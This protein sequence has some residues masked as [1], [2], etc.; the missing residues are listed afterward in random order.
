MHIDTVRFILGSL[1]VGLGVSMLPSMGWSIYYGESGAKVA[2]FYSIIIAVCF[3]ALLRFKAYPHKKLG[4]KE[5]FL[6]VACSWI[7]AGIFG[8]LPFVF[9]GAVDCFIDGF[10]EA[11]SGFTTT[12]ATVINDVEALPYGILFWRSFTHWLGG[13]GIIVLFL[14]ILPELSSG[15]FQ[16]FRAE[17]P[18]PSASKLS[19]RLTHTAK[20]LWSIYF[21]MTLLQTILLM[22]AGLDLFQALTHTF[23]SVA[24]GGFSTK[25]LSV[26]AFKNPAAEIIITI[27]MALAGI[28]FGLYYFLFK[29]EFRKFFR[30]EE[31]KFYLIIT[32]IA[33]L[34]IAWNIRSLIPSKDVLRTSAFQVVSIM[35]TTGYAT[36]NF[37]LWPGFSKFLLLILMFFG[38]CAGSTAGGLKHIRILVLLKVCL[39]E[40]TLVLHPKAI[41]PI[42][43]NGKVVPDHILRNIIVFS[44][45]YFLIFITGSLA[46]SFF[47]I[48]LVTSIS[49]VAA[50]LGNIGP[51]F[52]KVGPLCTF[53]ELPGLAKL[54][55]SFFMLLGRLELYTIILCLSPR[56][57]Q[58]IKFDIST[59]KHLSSQVLN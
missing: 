54:M 37:D 11:V 9:S 22:L 7:F 15:G 56:F 18:G 34:L 5:A 24:T 16:L 55:L 27:F 35:T 40:F 45:T 4:A 59:K 21:A 28:N 38:G 50:T 52:A 20:T 8:A 44:I 32:L 43:I 14:A 10:F 19:S 53:H 51:G 49:S 57:W 48:D 42:K 17:V 25:A 26:G 2:F 46:L 12:G 36:D 31:T 47:G 41:L 30:D 6:I 29:G 1:L 39:R 33:T 3:G 23:G 13:M 58:D